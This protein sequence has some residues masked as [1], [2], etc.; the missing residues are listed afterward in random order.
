MTRIT[1]NQISTWQNLIVKSRKDTISTLCSRALCSPWT[2]ATA[3]A[4]RIDQL[5]LR[6]G[7]IVV[8]CDLHVMGKGPAPDRT[9]SRVGGLPYRPIAL[10]WPHHVDGVPYRFFCQFDFSK[11]RDLF[12]GLPGDILLVFT[13]DETLVDNVSDHLRFE[14]HP[15]DS[16]T[17]LV[18]Q[19]DIPKYE[20]WN[21]I[22]YGFPCRTF[23]FLDE[24]AA[25]SA[26]YEL[27]GD[28]SIVDSTPDQSPGRFVGFKIGGLP[29]LWGQDPLDL[30]W[31]NAEGER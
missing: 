30:R 21:F 10:D 14:W 8:P 6:P 23:D 17:K 7:E 3:C 24:N 31:G 27:L 26:Y 15:I 16:A 29:S 18:E 25:Q 13:R 9:S 1:S 12:S 11:S 2:V 5:R 20:W 4:A 19:G 22:G 28:S